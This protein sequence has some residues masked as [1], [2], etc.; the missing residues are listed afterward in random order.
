[1][2][3]FT[4]DTSLRV[5]DLLSVKKELA[6]GSVE[7]LIPILFAANTKPAQEAVD[8]LMDLI[9]HEIH[10]FDVTAAYL[11]KDYEDDEV[12]SRSL[13]AFINGCKFFMTGNLS[14]RYAFVYVHKQS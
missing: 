11:M 9:K 12:V 13:E 2:F 7:S 5:N 10:S 14:W 1:M 3:T 4:A 8:A 6:G